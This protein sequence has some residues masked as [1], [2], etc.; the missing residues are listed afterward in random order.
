MSQEDKLEQGKLSS[1]PLLTKSLSDTGGNAFQR[2]RQSDN[3][4]YNTY[5]ETQRRWSGIISLLFR[6]KQS[7]FKLI[8]NDVL[9]FLVAYFLLSIL[10]R[11]VL[12][13]YPNHK[14]NFEI[15][16]IYAETF[17]SSIKIT[18]LIGFYVSQVVSRWWDQF[19]TLPYPDVLALKLVA[20]VPGRVSKV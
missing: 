10:Y 9:F 16:C 17:N 1:S 13:H 15:M 14:Q 3:I 12:Y 19:M 4:Y 11:H 7:V 2:I 20:F 6:W 8:W 18:F 5:S